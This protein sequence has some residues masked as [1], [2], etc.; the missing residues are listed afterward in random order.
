MRGV[1][2]IC[3]ALLGLAAPARADVIEIGQDGPH[4]VRPGPA[5]D[6]AEAMPDDGALPPALLTS[7]DATPA[8]PAAYASSIARIAAETRLSPALIEAVVWQESRWNAHAVSRAGAVGLAQLMPATARTLGVDPADPIANLQAGARYLRILLD[9][10][11]GDLVK[12]IA[13]YNAGPERVI[14]AGGVPPIAETRAY[15]AAITGRLSSS[16]LRVR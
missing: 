8:I 14:R 7:L 1:A 6:P 10:F 16:I 13:A 5:G 3:L 11:D 15:V 9:R 12:A 2:A 4:V